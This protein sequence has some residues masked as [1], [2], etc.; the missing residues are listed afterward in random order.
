MKVHSFMGKVGIEG[1]HQ[2]DNHINEW[3][4]DNK[5][6]V[7]DIQQSFGTHMHHDGRREEPVLLITVW[8]ETE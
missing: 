1:L 3:L 8:Y 6:K 5:A 2:M 7:I 4:A